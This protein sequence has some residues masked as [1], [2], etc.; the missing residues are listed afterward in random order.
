MVF[1]RSGVK[2]GESAKEEVMGVRYGDG[3]VGYVGVN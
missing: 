2:M 3:R 1:E